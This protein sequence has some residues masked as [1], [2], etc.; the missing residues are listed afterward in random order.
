MR[1]ITFFRLALVVL[2]VNSFIANAQQDYTITDF[3][4]L[5]GD[6]PTQNRSQQNFNSQEIENLRNLAFELNPLLF[7]NENEHKKIGEGAP[8]LVIVES[9]QLSQLASL[10]NETQSL[11]LILI[12]HSSTNSPATLDLNSLKTSSLK[13]V[14]I[15]CDYQ[16]TVPNIQSMLKN[17]S[18][19]KVLYRITTDQ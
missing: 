8:L 12:K 1:K 6:N 2:L 3:D 9:S 7:I 18:K 11:A 4:R 10:N 15:E 17:T 13:Y 5:I 14:L 16:C 19:V